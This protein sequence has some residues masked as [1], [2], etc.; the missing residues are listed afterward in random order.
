MPV[1]L[2][3]TNG[4]F[5]GKR[6]FVAR[7]QIAKIGRTEWADIS[8]PADSAMADIHFEVHADAPSCSLRDTSGGIGTLVNGA[9]ATD[10]TLHSGDTVSAGQTSFSVM[11][12]GEAVPAATASK[13]STPVSAAP[14]AE[15]EPTGPQTA[16]DY[17]R[18]LKMSDAAK[19]LLTEDLTPEDYLSLVIE[20]E[21]Y[22]DA[23]RF[24]AFWLPRPVAVGWACDCVEQL[25]SGTLKATDEAALKAA[26]VWSKEPNQ[27]NC[28]L[29]EKSATETGYNGP[30]CWLALAAFWSGD[31]L[32]PSDLQAVPPSEGLTAEAITGALMM[33][34]TQNFPTKAIDRY[35]EFLKNGRELNAKTN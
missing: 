8:F 4:P 7:G 24:L 35:R 14:A 30:S 28:R 2:Q 19:E 5:A 17:C 33:A 10:V 27:S 29:A 12:D 25:L 23:L 11:V 32:A 18:P 22:P 16:M 3:V 26:R 21:L 34:A 13:A 6:I 20:K 15:P 31:S 9:P 1:T